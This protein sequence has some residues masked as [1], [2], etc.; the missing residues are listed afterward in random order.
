VAPD[1]G[2]EAG[3]AGNRFPCQLA[4]KRLALLHIPTDRALRAP[5]YLGCLPWRVSEPTNEHE[6]ICDPRAFPPPQFI[7]DVFELETR[8]GVLGIGGLQP[9]QVSDDH[10]AL[11]RPLLAVVS[12]EIPGNG[13]EVR[14]G[15]DNPGNPITVGQ[16]VHS[17]DPLLEEVLPVLGVENLPRDN[18]PGVRAIV[19]DPLLEYLFLIRC[20]HWC[21]SP[22]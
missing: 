20:V 15:V 8:E 13:G 2:V 17:K 18:R 6:S 22:R 4:E 12:N 11:L 5:K 10:K 16:E 14:P 19:A 7:E 9:A 1:G 21:T 3:A